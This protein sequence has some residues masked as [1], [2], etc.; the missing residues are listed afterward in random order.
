MAA[1]MTRA[2]NLARKQAMPKTRTPSRRIAVV[3]ADPAWKKACPAA[4]ALVRRAARAALK[5]ASGPVEAAIALGSDALIRPL[6]RRYRRKDKPTNVL[7]FPA[8][9]THTDAEQPRNL[10]DVVLAL[11]TIRAEARAQRKPFV[12]HLAHLTVHGILHLLGYDHVRARDAAIMEKRE[13]EILTMLGL[14]D[15][16]APRPSGKGNRARAR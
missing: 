8:P 15:P 2:R 16:Y 10:G 12:N 5:E 11:E 6:N 3:I 13:I 1:T 9:H 7:S 14:P 4:P